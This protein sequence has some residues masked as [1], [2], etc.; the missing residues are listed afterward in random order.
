MAV[1]VMHQL[2]HMPLFSQ[3]ICL[4]QVFLKKT[5]RQLQGPQVV[6]EL[7]DVVGLDTAQ[8]IVCKLDLPAAIFQHSVRRL[9]RPSTGGSLADGNEI[10]EA[11][12]EAEG[13]NTNLS[14]EVGFEMETTV[15]GPAHDSPAILV[16]F[17]DGFLMRNQSFVAGLSTIQ[18]PLFAP[19][20]C[21]AVAPSYLLAADEASISHYRV[22]NRETLLD[23]SGK[24]NWNPV[25]SAPSDDASLRGFFTFQDMVSV[26]RVLSGLHLWCTKFGAR[27]AQVHDQMILQIVLDL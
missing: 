5:R 25:S 12:M 27:S 6:I 24:L 18:G 1:P 20:G 3:L 23:S 22:L 2:S 21:S 13:L 7:F 11:I 14:A 19:S 9:A 26:S 4:K 10:V 8:D 16:N 17:H 15:S